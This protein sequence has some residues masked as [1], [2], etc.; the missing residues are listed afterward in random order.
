MPLDIRVAQTV[1]EN[2]IRDAILLAMGERLPAVAN[3]AGLRAIITIGET[4]STRT[5]DDLAVIVVGGLVTASYRW[6]ATSAAADNG[7]SVVRP[8]DVPSTQPGRW[9]QWSST[10]RFSPVVGGPSFYL[11]ELASGVLQRVIILDRSMDHDEIAALIQGRVPSVVIEATGDSPNDLTMQTGYRWDTLYEFKVSTIAQNLRD[12]R[13]HAQDSPFPT[14]EPMV[15]GANTIDGFIKGL[16]SGSSLFSVVD[17]IR[18][19]QIGHGENWFSEFGQRRVIRSH[20]FLFQVTEENPNAPND[21]G[22]AEEAVLQA[23]LTDAHDAP[24][25]FDATTYLI[26]GMIVGTGP[27]LAKTVSAGNAVLD[28]IPVAYAGQ[29]RTFGAYSDTY[30]DLLP[31]GTMVFVEVAKEAEEPAVTATA[32]RIGVTSTDGSGVVSDRFIVATRAPY[33]NPIVVPLT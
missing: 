31:A 15:M 13:E 5:N 27:G 2:A 4:T 7:G 1:L 11:H 3:V 9:L 30:R 24:L 17:G 18:N 16:L 21:F 28:E 33:G 12:Y 25:P 14:D 29:L 20:A 32:T 26:D 19:V 6:S 23:E 10:L 8:N 22:P